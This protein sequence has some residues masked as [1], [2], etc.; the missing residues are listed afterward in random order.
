MKVRMKILYPVMFQ[1][2]AF[3]RMVH[4]EDAEMERERERKGEREVSVILKARLLL[5]FV[6]RLARALPQPMF[7]SCFYLN[8]LA[9]FVRARDSFPFVP[10]RT[11]GESNNDH[12]NQMLNVPYFQIGHL[13]WII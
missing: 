3:S 1:A 9:P 12:D 11:E 13:G 5:F 8:Y 10:F 4:I 2:F 7:V 6:V